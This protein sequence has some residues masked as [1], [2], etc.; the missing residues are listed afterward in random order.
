M[1]LP[2][3][4]VISLAWATC[5]REMMRARLD[6]RGFKY[7]IVDAVDGAALA[8]GDCGNRLR[9]D[10]MRRKYG[11]E[12]LPAEIG[13]YL[14]HYNLWARF[15]ADEIPCALVLEDDA[16]I[17]DDFASVVADV[18]ALNCRWD[19][20]H[21]AARRRELVDAAFR[22]LA[23]RDYVFG[24]FKQR[25]L[26]THAYLINLNGARKLLDICR[27]IS[28][29]VDRAWG[30]W[31]H[32]GLAFYCVSPDVA[33]G[34]E[35]ESTIVNYASLPKGKLTDRAAAF[36]WQ[37]KERLACRFRGWANPVPKVDRKGESNA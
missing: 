15:A 17:N 28:E 27:E 16:D 8:S 10:I 33:W 14:S 11:R 6:A 13:C 32:T 20:V 12:L 3:I 23:G 21:L 37:R 7:E 25:L 19:V 2:P 9:Q 31:W 5:R 26:G 36:V 35:P 29:P 30:H 22:G 34:V 4:F 24:R 18:L 1:T